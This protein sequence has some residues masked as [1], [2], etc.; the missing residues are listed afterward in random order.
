[1]KKLGLKH[2]RVGLLKRLGLPES[3]PITPQPSP[4]TSESDAIDDVD[5]LP[6]ELADYPGLR[7]L[8][9]Q[10]QKQRLESAEPGASP[11]SRRP[12]NDTSAEGA[13]APSS[14]TAVESPDALPNAAIGESIEH[15]K[16]SAVL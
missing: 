2:L 3:E 10:A 11:E 13:N 9:A 12:D 15:A 14:G 16:H 7:K 4:P 5:G 6:P 1:M 8:F